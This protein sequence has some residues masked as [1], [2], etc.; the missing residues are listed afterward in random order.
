MIYPAFF[1]IKIKGFIK[2]SLRLHNFYVKIT[3]AHSISFHVYNKYEAS[4]SNET[5]GRRQPE[6]VDFRNY[7]LTSDVRCVNQVQQIKAIFNLNYKG[8][9]GGGGGAHHLEQMTHAPKAI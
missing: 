9:G 2:L 3:Y 7:I 8:I 1:S 6:A 4:Q 5:R